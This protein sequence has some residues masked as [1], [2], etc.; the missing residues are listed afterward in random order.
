MALSDRTREKLTRSR[1]SKDGLIGSSL[2]IGACPLFVCGMFGLVWLIPSM[3]D[4][5]PS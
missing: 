1:H 2:L 4:T 5:I 3:D